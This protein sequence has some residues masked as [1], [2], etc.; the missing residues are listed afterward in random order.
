MRKIFLTGEAGSRCIEMGSL[1]EIRLY[2]EKLTF[3]ITGLDLV[4]Y[5]NRITER[6]LPVYAPLIDDLHSDYGGLLPDRSPS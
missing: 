2:K 6:R 4:T 1:V 5:T 3:I